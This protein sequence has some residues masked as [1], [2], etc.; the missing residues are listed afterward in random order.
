[1]FLYLIFSHL[2]Y[3][4]L[5]S[6]KNR[7]S[8]P[9]KIQKKFISIIEYFITFFSEKQVIREA[10]YFLLLY[11]IFKSCMLRHIQR[12]VIRKIYSN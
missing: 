1:M 11:L 12:V 7:K 2:R 9:L 3:Y 4:L 8:N 6:K 10:S 5:I